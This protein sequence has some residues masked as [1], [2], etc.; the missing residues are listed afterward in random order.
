M[1]NEPKHRGSKKKYIAVAGACAA[2]AVILTISHFAN[3]QILT[4]INN[5]DKEIHD[6]FISTSVPTLYENDT[7][8]I[9]IHQYDIR[10][11]SYIV[12]K[13]ASHVRLKLISPGEYDKTARACWDVYR[14]EMDKDYIDSLTQYME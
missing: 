9:Y 4:G 2:I 6:P 3:Y 12:F 14:V 11:P 1:Y 8:A 5:D 13:P 10:V 7:N